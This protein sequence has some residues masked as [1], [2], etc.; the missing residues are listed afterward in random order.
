MKTFLIDVGGLVVLELDNIQPL[1]DEIIE[2][3]TLK[4]YDPSRGA[5][6]RE[7]TSYRIVSRKWFCEPDDGKTSLICR[8][9]K[10]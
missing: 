7:A 1:V 2:V 5:H 6:I 10:A 8:V 9:F 4:K 3:V